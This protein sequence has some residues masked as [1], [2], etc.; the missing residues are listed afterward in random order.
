M[1]IILIIKKLRKR[2]NL[3]FP[4]QHENSTYVKTHCAK[5]LYSLTYDEIIRDIHPTLK[6]NTLE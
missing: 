2:T 5:N 3:F 1:T 4:N 6:F